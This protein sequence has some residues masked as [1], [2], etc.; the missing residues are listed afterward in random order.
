MRK[1][2]SIKL[3]HTTMKK[4]VL[5]TMV[6]VG[7]FAIQKIV[8][9]EI[10]DANNDGVVNVADVVAAVNAAKGQQSD[11]FNLS[12]A[13]MNGDGVITLEDAKLIARKI[14]SPEMDLSNALYD[15]YER[16]FAKGY[17]AKGYYYYDRKQQITSQEF[18]AMLK[19]LVEKYSPDKMDYF[20]SRVSDN[21]VPLTRALAVGMAYYAAR[22]IGATSRN[23]DTG[24]ESAADF[25]DNLW[26]QQLD[27][28][29][30]L[31]GQEMEGDE[32]GWN[33]MIYACLW[34]SSHGSYYS[35]N[36]VIG[37][38]DESSAW[39]WN[40][41]FVWEDAIRAVTRLNDS[42]EPEIV[43]VDIN[44]PRVTTPDALSIT[45]EL[46]AEAAQK[47]IH[48]INELPR[49]YGFQ[50]GENLAPY[51]KDFK[52]LELTARDLA[53]RASW[54]FNSMRY[55]LP[56]WAL[57][58]SDMKQANLS[59]LQALDE[60]VATA[61]EK[62]MHLQFSFSDIPGRGQWLQEDPTLPYVLDQDILNT[63]KRRQARLLFNIIATRYKDV[64]NN[65]LI[66]TPFCGP[67]PQILL[68]PSGFGE[69]KTFTEEEVVDFIDM[70]I[71]AIREKSP[72]RFIIYE[73]FYG[74]LSY[75]NKDQ[76]QMAKDHYKHISEKYDNIL[77]VFNHMDMSYAFYTYTQGDGN[78]DYASHST[79]MPY[80]PFQQYSVLGNIGGENDQL[81]INGCLPKGT[82]LEFN[83]ATAFYAELIIVADGKELYKE[84]LPG[85]NQYEVGY[86]SCWG[87]PFR[88][89]EKVVTITLEED[90]TEITL[91]PGTGWVSFS[92]I[93][94]ILPDSYG[95]ER[96]RRDSQWDVQLG[97]LAPEDYHDEFYK[98]KTSTVQ[99]GSWGEKGSTIT[100]HDDVS[101][102]TAELGLHSDADFYES[103]I[104]KYS[105]IAPRWTCRFED[106]NSTDY[107]SSLRFW[108]ATMELFK[109]Y[110]IDVWISA[111]IH[112]MEPYPYYA[113]YHVAG[114]QGEQ[115]GR[116]HNFNVKL[117]RILQKYVDK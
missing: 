17:L 36:E 113:P 57:F 23:I 104:Q 65:N 4:I 112:L 102:T 111:S 66:L 95:V 90:A 35:Q 25:W 107:D 108:D 114:Y 71:D 33:E 59:M 49:M 84:S 34:N 45:P 13:D 7:V 41:T 20:N 22:C 76:F 46:I 69:A 116:H 18:K 77:P 29:L 117:L 72:E 105:E 103:L 89:S 24:R 106:I 14:L 74:T 86:G 62:G 9:A 98:K 10:G 78:I 87:E 27:L 82:V 39:S 3:H 99:I 12:A 88:P 1:E 100:I 30:P 109:K 42:F 31:S 51:T 56:Y 55:I 28:V 94:V 81:T 38:D 50:E 26:D 70:L 15:D 75:E 47:E 115:F 63:E 101:Y 52:K 48:N 5:V 110:N 91:S 40:K 32:N 11:H 97:I 43:Y 80:W 6:L 53:E 93:N 64:P 79:W 2:V 96:W 8:A 83:L 58:T 67:G 16:A 92:G 73:E 68:D 37:F 61:M 85:D 44:D 21:D 60:L 19:P 54:G